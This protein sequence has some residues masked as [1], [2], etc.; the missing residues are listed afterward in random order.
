[1]EKHNP[2]GPT[3]V[4]DAHQASP[5]EPSSREIHVL[6]GCADARD[7]GATLADAIASV[8]ARYL[9][10][11]VL[12]VFHALRTAGSFVTRDVIDDV[13]RIV[14]IEERRSAVPTRYFVHIQTHG[15]VSVGEHE[16]G[17]SGIEHLSI[18]PGSP[19]NCGMLGA[20]GVSVE[21]ERL[22][23]RLQPTLRFHGRERAVRSEDDIRA[24]LLEVYAYRGSIAGDWIR[25]IDDLRTHPRLQES[26]L[27]EA[28]S[29]DRTLRNVD[30]TITTGIQDYR[31]HAY[32]RLDAHPE[33][34]TFWDDVYVEL[35][36]RTA[37]LP[38]EDGEHLQRTAK[39]APEVGL[40]S[41]CDFPHARQVAVSHL[42][43]VRGQE[44]TE[45]GPNQVFTFASESFDL[46]HSPFGPYTVAGFYYAV[47][48]LRLRDFVVLGHDE[49]QTR[50]MLLRL[51]NDPF[52]HLITQAFGVRFHPFATPLPRVDGH[53][54]V[55]S[56]R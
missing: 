15:E 11:G 26:V 39:Q 27:R 42:A 30:L 23:L 25:S 21:L 47:A 6:V 5:D 4:H 41:T 54:G 20:S 53:V 13:R 14:E 24:L 18:V 38:P 48:H 19:F 45:F 44:P 29:A 32:H 43:A 31:Q 35:R 51:E 49:P 12:V 22:V 3:P 7:V 8:S 33:R 16:H 10:K 37:A 40:F 1:M 56:A 9:E 17:R 46:P 55:P 52:V 34:A 50:R 28:I 36:E 2:A